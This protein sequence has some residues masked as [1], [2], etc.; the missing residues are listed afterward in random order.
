MPSS[1]AVASTAFC[2]FTR[3]TSARRRANTSSM[4]R[5]WDSV[6]IG[7]NGTNRSASSQASI[8]GMTPT[9]VAACPSTLTT[10]PMTS[11]SAANCRRQSP[12]PSTTTG[13]GAPA[14]VSSAWNPRPTTGATSMSAKKPASTCRV[15]TV[16]GVSMP[17][18]LARREYVAD[19][20]SKRSPRSPS[21]V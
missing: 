21:A 5:D 16:T 7:W 19:T 17:P 1:T 18:R 2:A 6:T 12:L 10:R 3:G 4:R 8:Q 20:T 14:R 11:G 15:S 13:A 9:M